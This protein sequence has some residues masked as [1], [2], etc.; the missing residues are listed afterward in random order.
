[1][2]KLVRILVTLFFGIFG[3][4]HFLDGKVGLGLLYLFTAG[5][6]GIGWIVDV[7]KALFQSPEEFDESNRRYIQLKEQRKIVGNNRQEI[8]QNELAIK[9]DRS[10]ELKAQG[11]AHCPKCNGITLQYV[12]RRKKLSAGRAIVGGVA[13]G[14]VGAIL[15]ATTSNKHKGYIKCLSCGNLYKN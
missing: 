11:I 13:L 3:V 10:A 12:E 7:F 4:H 5:L 14:G 8:Y 6:F 2:S 15:G 1:M 9:Q